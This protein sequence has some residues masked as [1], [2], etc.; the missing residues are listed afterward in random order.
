MEFT[1]AQNMAGQWA[2]QGRSRKSRKLQSTGER[3]QSLLGVEVDVGDPAMKPSWG[4]QEPPIPAQVTAIFPKPTPPHSQST[5]AN[6]RQVRTAPL[7]LQT[8]CQ[9]PQAVKKKKKSQQL[10]LALPNVD[11]RGPSTRELHG[12]WSKW[13]LNQ[14]S[15]GMA[16]PQAAASSVVPH[17]PFEFF[18]L[19]SSKKKQV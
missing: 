1:Q 4:S 6:V 10:H 18:C 8:F 2:A 3:R 16:V 12:K 5:K 11:D 15:Y 13:D 7:C 9:Q 14:H 19:F 17:Q